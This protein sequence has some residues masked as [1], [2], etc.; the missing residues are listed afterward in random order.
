MS[1]GVPHIKAV[2]AIPLAIGNP[3]AL[4][5]TKDEVSRC[6]A[7]QQPIQRRDC[8]KSLKKGPKAKAEEAAKAKTENAPSPRRRM[9]QPPPL[10]AQDQEPRRAS[11]APGRPRRTGSAYGCAHREALLDGNASFS[12]PDSAPHPRFRA[13]CRQRGAR[14]TARSSGRNLA[15]VSLRLAR[16][17]LQPAGF[18]RDSIS[19]EKSITGEPRSEIASCFCPEDRKFS[20]R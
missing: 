15:P 10:L 16:N 19:Q 18:L 6:R 13:L 7:I 5:A 9:S 3:V 12:V 11:S 17:H 1:F 14:E 2:A 4:A 8:F 20:P